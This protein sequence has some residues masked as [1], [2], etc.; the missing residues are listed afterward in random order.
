MKIQLA[1]GDALIVV[2]VQRD[3]LPGGSLSV[4]Q[5][6]E[7]VSVLNRYLALF[8]IKNLPVFATRDWHPPD[9]C[10]FSEQGGAWSAHCI[11]GSPGA[12]FPENLD[13][14]GS[15]HIV[16]KA[17]A[18]EKEAYSG[19]AG[20]RLDDLLRAGGVRRVFVGGLATDY[21]VLH[22]VKDALSCGYTTLLL[23]DA[24]RAVDARSGDGQRAIMEMLGLGA[25]AVRLEDIAA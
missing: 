1:N 16:S 19:F 11:A 5:G 6:E 17:D 18:P 12:A 3:F 13:L 25:I 9:H 23:E 4:P 10:S 20:T 22:T 15:A 2:D 8:R 14:P 7:V 21:C 24:V